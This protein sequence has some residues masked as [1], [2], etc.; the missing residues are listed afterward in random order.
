MAGWPVTNY[1]HDYHMVYMEKLIDA[2]FLV[3]TTSL[4]YMK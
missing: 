1:N 4:K 3:Q 2:F